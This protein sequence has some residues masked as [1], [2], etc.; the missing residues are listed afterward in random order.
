MSGLLWGSDIK[1]LEC[2]N[3]AVKCFRTRMEKLV[4]EK[5]TYKGVGK[6][7]EKM[8][9]RLTK[10]ART[11]PGGGSTASNTQTPGGFDE[12]STALLWLPCQL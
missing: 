4:T 11:K 9:K 2:A 3:H 7:T 8:R 1:K 6:L 12:S 10:S 5:P